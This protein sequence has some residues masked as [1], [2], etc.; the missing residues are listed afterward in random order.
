MIE[1]SNRKKEKQEEEKKR[2]RAKLL[3]ELASCSIK[4]QST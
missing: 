4:T 2:E 1:G 3:E